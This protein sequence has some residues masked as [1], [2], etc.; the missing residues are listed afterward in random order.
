MGTIGVLDECVRSEYAINRYYDPST[1]QFLSV[2]PLVDQTGQPYVY[3]NDNPLNATDP[4]GL[5]ISGTGSAVCNRQQNE[6]GVGI[7]EC[8]G[9]T[10]GGQ[11]ALGV[12]VAL[13]TVEFSVGVGTVTLSQ[14]FSV[15]G[16][17]DMSFG[18]GGVT[19]SHGGGSETFSLDGSTSGS[20]SVP[21]IPSLAFTNGGIAV[22]ATTHGHL[23]GDKVEVDTTATF[24]PESGSPPPITTSTTYLAVD[25]GG[26][27]A[28]WWLG[29]L[30]SPLCGP[31]LPG[32]AVAL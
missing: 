32:C 4:L 21:G 29:K 18:S 13:P 12:I 2:D 27:A 22:S 14:T 10:A 30:L 20:L 11:S 1:D 26:V 6:S 3:V 25:A 24:Y 8:N 17:Y 19:V 28:L 31:A 23:G 7:L 15:S 5:M 9:Q 16:S